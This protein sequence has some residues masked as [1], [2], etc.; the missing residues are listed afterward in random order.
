MMATAMSFA[1]KRPIN[2]QVNT[3]IDW[4]KRTLLI[5]R[6]GPAEVSPAHSVDVV[7]GANGEDGRIPRQLSNAHPEDDAFYVLEWTLSFLTG[8]SWV[9]A[10][11]GPFVLAPEVFFT[12]TLWVL[13]VRR[14]V[15]RTPR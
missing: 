7:R 8:D 14:Q 1:A 15:P 3:H 9:D 6:R 10:S 5:H 2:N 13:G 4:R 12:T 11:R